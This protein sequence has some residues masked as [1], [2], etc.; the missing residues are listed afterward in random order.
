MGKIL[1]KP[2]VNGSF[3]VSTLTR[4]EVLKS[5]EII[6]EDGVLMKDEELEDLKNEYYEKGKADAVEEARQMVENAKNE[7]FEEGVPVGRDEA[8][9]E[10]KPKYL[11]MKTV[12]D[13]WNEAKDGLLR[14]LETDAVEL[15]L[16]I[17]KKIVGYE[18][19]K[20]KEPLKFV[21]R[22]ALNS[23]ISRK[24]LRLRVSIEDEEYLKGGADDFV[25]TMGVDIEVIGDS[26]IK[27]GGCVVESDFGK[28][29]AGLE[30]RWG[31]VISKFFEGIKRGDNDVYRDM[32]ADIGNDESDEVGGQGDEDIGVIS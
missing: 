7:G 17:E 23:V 19:Q 5:Q 24:N 27:Q 28:L 9:E 25:K 8:S 29:E 2:I 22:E 16:A 18:I 32:F 26:N 6:Y 10:L 1:S 13:E 14:E 20:S 21:I 11:A 30:E 31:M 12:F 15:S 3:F 4:E